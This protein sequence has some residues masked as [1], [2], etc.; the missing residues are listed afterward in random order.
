MVGD[1][2]P[3]YFGSWTFELTLNLH[4]PN[5]QRKRHVRMILMEHVKGARNMSRMGPSLIPETTSLHILSRIL[6]AE[7]SAKNFGV[8]H[9][10]VSP[11][12]VA[13]S[14]KDDNVGGPDSVDRV[15]LLDFKIAWSKQPAL[16]TGGDRLPHHPVRCRWNSAGWLFRELEDW[17]PAEW[18]RTRTVSAFN[19]WLL[20]QWKDSATWT[21]VWD[22][23]MAIEGP[24]EPYEKTPTP[25]EVGDPHGLDSQE[26][27]V[28]KLGDEKDDSEAT[29]GNK[30]GKSMVSSISPQHFADSKSRA[31][32]VGAL[33][34]TTRIV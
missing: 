30:S 12:N 15:I 33:A 8:E 18:R 17:M 6:D 7:I 10:D 26:L 14:F 24:L 27:P 20:T 3:K 23:L 13:A 32:S 4:Q 5:G 19:D 28:P 22:L 2:I 1:L 11:R 16:G 21:E 9:D 25:L 31:G 29:R 34:G